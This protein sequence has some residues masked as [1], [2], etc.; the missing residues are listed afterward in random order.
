Q[1]VFPAG[2]GGCTR[3]RRAIPAASQH[4][5]GASPHQLF[6][7][8]RKLSQSRKWYQ[9]CGARSH[10]RATEYQRKR[11]GLDRDYARRLRARFAAALVEW[12]PR[13]SPRWTDPKKYLYSFRSC[14]PSRPRRIA[15]KEE[16]ENNQAVACTGPRTT[17]KRFCRQFDRCL[18]I[19]S[20]SA[21]SKP[22]SAPAFS[23]SIHLCFK[24]SSR[25]ARNSL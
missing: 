1:C 12:L 10:F 8:G 11:F 17:F 5:R 23:L 14:L 20:S 3:G 22:I 16:T 21:F 19:Q 7:R 6:Q 2:A 9:Q 15:L 18:T 24:I 13:P 25:S 4:H